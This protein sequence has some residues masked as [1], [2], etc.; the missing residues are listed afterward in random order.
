VGKEPDKDD[1]DKESIKNKR[2]PLSVVVPVWRSPDLP[3]GEIRPRERTISVRGVDL[4]K[5]E[6]AE[7]VRIE[8]H[9]IGYETSDDSLQPV[10]RKRKTTSAKKRGVYDEDLLEFE[11]Y[12]L[13]QIPT[14][15]PT[16]KD[17]AAYFLAQMKKKGNSNRFV[18]KLFEYFFF[19]LLYWKANE[20]LE[21]SGDYL[22]ALFDCELDYAGAFSSPKEDQAK[23]FKAVR[24]FLQGRLPLDPKILL[25]PELCQVFFNQNL[26]NMHMQS[27]SRRLSAYSSEPVPEASI[28]FPTMHRR[29]NKLR[30]LS[31]LSLF[32]GEGTWPGYGKT[33]PY[34]DPFCMLLGRKI[35][36]EMDL[37][38]TLISIFICYLMGII[39]EYPV[40]VE[41]DYTETKNQSN[42]PPR[43]EDG[44]DEYLGLCSYKLRDDGHGYETKIS[45]KMQN[46]RDF[47][48]ERE[49]DPVGVMIV[50]YIHELVHYTYLN[51]SPLFGKSFYPFDTSE[52]YRPG[53]FGDISFH[54]T[55][56]QLL[57]NKV[58]QKEPILLGIFEK[59]LQ[60]QPTVYGDWK[61]FQSMEL[62]KL[63]QAIR[64]SNEPN[65]RDVKVF[66]EAISSGNRAH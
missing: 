28:V 58:L 54:E 20:V 61:A 21:I 55:M 51:G 41:L 33:F 35:G 13:S 37:S 40:Y 15:T 30:Y 60:F 2:I 6:G 11:E 66:Q 45:L 25:D 32:S 29:T 44:I 65:M 64:N 9:V 34:F 18:N 46:I 49:L 4:S 3:K 63:Q 56:A 43:L 52:Q 31:A 62:G 38:S 8:D 10:R 5:Q 22:P 27:R 24:E 57:T 12:V 14:P 1:K 53:Q 59:M 39:L 26:R 42:E 19:R 48:E 23:V 16:P 50:V 47:S 36:V 7:G 17:I